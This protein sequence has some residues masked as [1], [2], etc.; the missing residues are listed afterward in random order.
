MTRA[1]WDTPIHDWFGLSYS[2]YLCIPRSALEAMPVGWQE[3]LVAL[4][5]EA[6]TLGL[7]TPKYTV[8]RRASSGRFIKDPWADYRRGDIQA[9][10]PEPLRRTS[11]EVDG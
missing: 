2:S 11:N 10:L 5:D 1:S 4:L 3:R 6:D 7:E 9:L 8:Q